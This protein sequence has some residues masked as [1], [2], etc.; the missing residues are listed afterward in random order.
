MTE[1]EKAQRVLET[2][3]AAEATEPKAA[4]AMLN[5]LMELLRSPSGEESLEI[6]EARSAA[7]LSI[8]EVGKA[9]HRCQPA[10]PLWAGAVAATKHWVALAR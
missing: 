6:D 9:L 7:F 5:G 2:L 8:C 10:E 3:K 1:Q 4:L